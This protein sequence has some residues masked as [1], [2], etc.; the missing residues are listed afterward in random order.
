M[1]Y[2]DVIA[3][4]GT[5]HTVLEVSQV[6]VYDPFRGQQRIGTMGFRA[7]VSTHHIIFSEDPKYPYT[8]YVGLPCQ[9]SQLWFRVDT[10][11][12]DI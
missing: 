11:R 12:L 2:S 7:C 8:E 3:R 5:H 6:L 9:A 10:F 4:P 1:K